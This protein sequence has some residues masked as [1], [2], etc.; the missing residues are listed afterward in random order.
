MQDDWDKFNSFEEYDAF[1]QN[2]LG[3]CYRVL[4]DTGTIWVIGSYHNIFRI[5]KIL[6]DIGF[7]ILNDII[8]I[9]TNPTPNFKG[10]R[11]NNSHE[12]LIWATKSQKSKYTFH[13][14]SLK[15]MN[16]DLQMRSD[17]YIPIC[18]GSERLKVNGKKV[19]ST[20]KPEELLYRIIISTSNIDDIVLD[21]F[22]SSGTTA[23]IAKKLGRNFIAFERDTFYVEASRER[24]SKIIPFEKKHLEYIIERKQPR[25][26][27]VNL[28]ESQIISPGEKLYSKDK[29]FVCEVQADGTVIS[30]GVVGSI[31]KVSAKLINKE[32]SNGWTFCYLERNGKMILLDELRKLYLRDFIIYNN[33]QGQKNM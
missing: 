14:H 26:P 20:Q 4:K 8:W 27:F 16:V 17:W 29:R 30:N 3:Q 33:L 10:T 18:Q 1:T 2:W 32:S 9:K 6:Q 24:I 7:W 28:I 31:H 21:P 12:T 22:S 25:V 11:F 15:S 19:H 23:A 5:G 13:Y